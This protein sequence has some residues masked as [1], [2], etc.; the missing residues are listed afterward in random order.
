MKCNFISSLLKNKGA[1]M[2]K[3]FAC[4][5]A[6]L[7]LCAGC[8]TAKA[9]PDEVTLAAAARMETRIEAGTKIALINITSPS[10]AFSEY[11]LDELSGVLVNS[12]RLVVVDR[13]SLDRVRHEL[14][15]NASGEVSDESAQRI[16]VMLGAQALVTGSLTSFGSFHRLTHCC[17]V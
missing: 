5:L 13:A 14:G 8:A 16:G 12:G 6:S 2:K 9:N 11:V 4:A 15:F 10:A 17:P 3:L 7:F 1:N